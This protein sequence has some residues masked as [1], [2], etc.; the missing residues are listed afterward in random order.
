MQGSKGIRQWPMNWFT[1]PMMIHKITSSVDYNECFKCFDTQ[2]NE[3]TNQNSIRFPK[4]LS[5]RIR[6]RYY[7]TLETSVITA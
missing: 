7:Y 5:Q 2:I 3:P 6:K 1:S 4:F